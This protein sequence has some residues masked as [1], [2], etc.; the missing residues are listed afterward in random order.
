MDTGGQR[1]TSQARCHRHPRPI[2][3]RGSR[4][5]AR[6]PA[7]FLEE[8]PPRHGQARPHEHG[9]PSETRPA[10]V[11]PTRPPTS[12]VWANRSTD[13]SRRPG[14]RLEKGSQPHHFDP[15][16]DASVSVARSCGCPPLPPSSVKRDR[17][18]GALGVP[19]GDRARSRHL[20]RRAPP[21]IFEAASSNR[22]SERKC[23]L[24]SGRPPEV[25]AGRR[26]R[27]LA[28]GAVDKVAGPG[29]R[30]HGSARDD[31]GEGNGT[32]EANDVVPVEVPGLGGQAAPK[33][34]DVAELSAR[35]SRAETT[36][37]SH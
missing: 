1:V 4:S 21:Q 34:E 30:D 8:A 22:V 19:H 25:P 26:W 9:A 11:W 2:R 28:D 37:K 13:R 17:S 12:P 29:I 10:R 36:D 24:R 15:T 20:T 7:L 35:S 33:P 16:A 31:D 3:Q 18:F 23:R 27:C 5:V 6:S 14:L 32:P